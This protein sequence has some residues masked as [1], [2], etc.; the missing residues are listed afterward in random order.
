MDKL[1]GRLAIA[2]AAIGLALGT[3]AP[4]QAANI[5]TNG[6]FETGTFAGWTQ[7]G[8]TGFTGVQCPGGQPDGNCSAFFGPIGSIGSISQTLTTLANTQYEIDFS[9]QTDGGVTSSFSGSFGGVTFVSQTNP[10][11]HGFQTF[12]FGGLSTGTSTALVF[13]FRDDPG[14]I[15]IDA[16]SVSVAVPGPATLVL[17]GLGLVGLSLGLRRRILG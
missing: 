11:A 14:F 9:L 7:S 17:V 12:S 1:T 2:V 5:V 4:A 10:P 13:S 3:I 16:I 6:S 15:L 8:N